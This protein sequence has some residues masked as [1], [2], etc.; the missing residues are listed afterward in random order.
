MMGAR[1]LVVCTANV[2]RSPMGQALLQRELL[3]VGRDD[4]VTSAGT[5]GANLPADPVAMAAL[6]ALGAPLVGHTPRRATREILNTDGAD[7]ILAMTR[8]HVRELVAVN[9][10]VWKRTFTLREA[11]RRAALR[12]ADWYEPIQYPSLADW[13]VDIAADRHPSDLMGSDPIDD[14][15]DPNGRGRGHVDRAAADIADL[16]AQFARAIPRIG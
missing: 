7:I 2:C 1:I 12:A 8:Q 3:A 6:D 4:I 16:A 5:T 13:L 15:D 10:S 14:V 11:V 9:P